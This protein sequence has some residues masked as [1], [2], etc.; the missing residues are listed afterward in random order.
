MGKEKI[1]R[2]LLHVDEPRLVDTCAVVSVDIGYSFIDSK[3]KIG[4]P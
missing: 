2:L 4:K 3:S 1:F